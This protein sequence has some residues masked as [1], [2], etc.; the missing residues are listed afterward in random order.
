M[1]NL[2]SLNDFYEVNELFLQES[3]TE[4]EK[5]EGLEPMEEFIKVCVTKHAFER[6]NC[7]FERFCEYEWVEK[8]ILKKATEILNLPMNKDFVLMA[9][10]HKLAVV[11]RMEMIDGYLSLVL[12]TVIRNIIVD[13]NGNEVEK[14]V[15]V[16]KNSKIV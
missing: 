5:E 4:E 15:W 12:I 8:L 16:R 7:N 10:D 6:M 9:E 2:M 13:G 11:G 14:R 3:L 1:S